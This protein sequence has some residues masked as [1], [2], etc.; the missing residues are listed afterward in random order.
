MATH[1]FEDD[2]TMAAATFAIGERAKDTAM[3]LPKLDESFSLRGAMHAE[4]AE[5]GDVFSSYPRVS[6]L[7][8]G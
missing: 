8:R 2:H 3:Q 6:R 4:L 1:D 7:S 5:T